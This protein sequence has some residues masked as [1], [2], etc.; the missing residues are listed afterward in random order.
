M[1]RVK[2]PAKPKLI[3]ALMTGETGLLEKAKEVLRGEYGDIDVESQVYPFDYTDYYREEMGD[4][5]LKQFVSFERL[6]AMDSLPQIKRFTNRLEEEFGRKE[7]DR[8]YRRINVDP[9]YVSGAKLVLATTKDYDHRIYLGQ[10]IFAE[11]TLRY[12]KGGFEHLEWTYPDYRTELAKEF[13]K[14]VR[15]RYLQQLRGL[16][17][18]PEALL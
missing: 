17:S 2:I 11:V 12:R 18:T 5:L 9:G 4:G 16:S 6:I 15:E 1:G 3:A 8:I 13:F 10:G 14:L 7:G